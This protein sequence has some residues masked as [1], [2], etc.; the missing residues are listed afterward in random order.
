[1]S[2][3]AKQGYNWQ[4]MADNS[5]RITIRITKRNLTSYNTWCQ[6]AGIRAFL[7]ALAGDDDTYDLAAHRAK[8]GVEG[9]NDD[10]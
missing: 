5:K 7:R 10:D 9:G 2:A 4:T 1:M 3:T 8:F 6:S